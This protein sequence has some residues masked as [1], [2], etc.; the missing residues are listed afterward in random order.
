MKIAARLLI[1]LL[2]VF[3]Q[4]PGANAAF[5][6][7]LYVMSGTTSVPNSYYST[8][9]AYPAYQVQ[10]YDTD[11]LMDTTNYKQFI[12]PVGVSKVRLKCGVVL[13]PDTGGAAA[14]QG[15]IA[16]NNLG[17]PGLNSYPELTPANQSSVKGV[18]T[19][20]L[21]IST[22]VLPVVAGDKFQCAIWQQQTTGAGP[23]RTI[24]VSSFSIEIIE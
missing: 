20:D 6:G 19:D 7:A 5:R 16:K 3:A 12:V 10:K 4:I 15:L 18:T 21:I 24:L 23:A 11:N 14:V 13:A 17:L 1:P 22:H 2:L 9:Y 8:T